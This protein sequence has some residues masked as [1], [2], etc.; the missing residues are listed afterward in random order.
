MAGGDIDPRQRRGGSADRRGCGQG[1][2]RQLLH[3][4]RFSG[5]RMSPGFD[6]PP[7]LLVQLW[8]VETNDAG[9]RL[10]M[11][12]AA[13]GRHQSVGMPRRDF[14]VIAEHGIVPD[15]ERRD[16]GQLA[17]PVL[18]RGNCPATI[19]RGRPQGIER[20]VIALGDVAALR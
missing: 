3:V 20:G 18:E 10:A 1:Q 17:V 7:R 13:V 8:R 12:E 19:R 4:R 9:E 15:L 11:R 16:S 2:R 6:H 14:D 5:Q